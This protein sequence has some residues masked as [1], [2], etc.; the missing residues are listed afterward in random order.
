LRIYYYINFRAMKQNQPWVSPLTCSTSVK[1][2]LS[3]GLE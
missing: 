3:D 2:N 1:T